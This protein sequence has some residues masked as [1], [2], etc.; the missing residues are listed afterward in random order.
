MVVGPSDVG[1]STVCKLLLNYAA[2]MNRAPIYVD[3]DVGQVGKQHLQYILNRT[4]NTT[5]YVCKKTLLMINV[6]VLPPNLTYLSPYYPLSLP[7]TR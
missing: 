2:R 6:T 5:E 1:K 7:I 3:L 4:G